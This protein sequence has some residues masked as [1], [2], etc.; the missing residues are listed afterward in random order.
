MTTIE[1]IKTM[2]DD[3]QGVVDQAKDEVTLDPA[4]V[5][6]GIRVKCYRNLLK[7]IESNEGENI[8]ELFA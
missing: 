6:A 2:L 1:R 7:I 4:V 3:E 5:E 8:H